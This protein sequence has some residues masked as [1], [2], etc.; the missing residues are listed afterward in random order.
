MDACCG[1]SD[2]KRPRLSCYTLF[3]VLAP[4]KFIELR[5]LTPLHAF[6]AQCKEADKVSRAINV[7]ITVLGGRGIPS[8]VTRSTMSIWSCW[9]SMWDMGY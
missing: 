9:I 6:Q 7:A 1:F 2:Q 4:D 8:R 5:L 3:S